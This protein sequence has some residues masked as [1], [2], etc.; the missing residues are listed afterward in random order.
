VTDCTHDP[1]RLAITA[2]GPSSRSR[3]LPLCVSTAGHAGQCDKHVV[4]TAAGLTNTD[5]SS[6]ADYLTTVM[7]WVHQRL[8]DTGAGV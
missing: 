3:N 6:P 2:L 5:P 4:T 1:L 7:D 8:A